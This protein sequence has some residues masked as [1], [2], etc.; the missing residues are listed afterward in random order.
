MSFPNYVH[1]AILDA[2]ELRGNET[3]ITTAAGEY[4]F[5]F[6]ERSTLVL[7]AA[8]FVKTGILEVHF[9]HALVLRLTISPP[10]SDV[11]GPSWVARSIEECKEGEWIAELTQLD[12]QLLAYEGEQTKKEEALRRDELRV[13]DE[14]K[15]KLA[16][17]PSLEAKEVSWFRRLFL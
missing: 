13:V 4:V 1:P 11:V 5:M 9:N 7:E 14:I 12:S 3:K 2:V 6:N 10:D 16:K 8:E 17:L 15:E